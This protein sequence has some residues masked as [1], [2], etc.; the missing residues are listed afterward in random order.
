MEE[1]ASESKSL[2]MNQYDG[3]MFAEACGPSK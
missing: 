3:G 1:I 2:E